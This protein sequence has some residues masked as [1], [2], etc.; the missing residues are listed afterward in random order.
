MTK[1]QMKDVIR[2]AL[3]KEHKLDERCITSYEWREI[4]VYLDECFDAIDKHISG[5][6]NQ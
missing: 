2:E 1:S 3:E 4:F 5:K 6:E